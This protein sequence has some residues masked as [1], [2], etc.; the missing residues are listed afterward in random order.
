VA[1][2]QPPTGPYPV[3]RVDRVVNDTTRRNRYHISTNGAFPITVWYPAR[4]AA[5]QQPAVY[6]PAAVTRDP[7]VWDIVDR[8]AY[9]SSYSVQDAPFADGLGKVPVVFW[10]HGYPDYRFDGAELAEHLASYGYA[11]VGIDHAD[12]PKP[13]F[14]DGRY[15]YTDPDSNGTN[16]SVAVLQNRALDLTVTLDELTRLSE[17][18]N[19]PVLG[20]RLD[21]ENVAGIGWSYGGGTVGEFCRRSARQSGRGARRLYAKRS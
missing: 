7:R 19:D 5:R 20:G 18:Q 9:L 14:P 17:Q 4:R 16:N 1:P 2:Q 13:V 21:V 6:E 12:C 3:G 11:V 8:V 10:S 15:L